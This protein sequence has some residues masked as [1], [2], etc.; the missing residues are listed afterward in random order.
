MYEP[1]RAARTTRLTIR[2]LHYHLR[3]WGENDMPALLL[4][5]G[6]MDCGATFQFTVDQLPR[7]WRII[8]PDWRG[9]GD[10][11][12]APDGYYFPEYLADLDALIAEISP[13]AP[14][15]LVGHSMG[16]NIA[17]L[18]AG[19]RPERVARLA[20]LEGFGLPPTDPAQ[21]PGRYRSW[22]D[23]QRSAWPRRRYS[24]F[25]ELAAK[26]SRNNP[27]LERDTAAF[28]ARCWAEA[29]EAGGVVL[30]ADPR[31]KMRN[32]ILYR[33]EESRACW[34]RIRAPTLWVSGALSP[35]GK[36]DPAMLKEN[37]KCYSDLREVIVAD[38]GHMMH[39][40]QPS[41]LARLLTEFL[42]PALS[43]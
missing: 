5:H 38:A 32:P 14:V 25:D 42:S 2:G 8:A 10:S 37:R 19:I 27:R 43:A 7:D 9:F 15:A 41:A 17:T 40:E 3:C 6:W 30:R 16:G 39:H 4:L 33:L 36:M 31:H 24:G 1:A 12:W 23:Q 20:T 11:E 21:A 18:Y 22:L 13:N 34:R 28:I 35:F 29:D 26:I